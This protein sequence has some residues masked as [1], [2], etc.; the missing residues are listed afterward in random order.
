MF[1][2]A[3]GRAVAKA[4]VDHCIDGQEVCHGTGKET[5]IWEQ[6]RYTGS[7]ER[8]IKKKRGEMQMER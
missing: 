3:E 7:G 5:T 6:E 2:C 4:S 8:K 1:D